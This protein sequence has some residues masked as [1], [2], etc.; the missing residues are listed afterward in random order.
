MLRGLFPPSTGKRYPPQR[1]FPKLSRED[2]HLPDRLTDYSC[3]SNATI[4]ESNFHGYLHILSPVPCLVVMRPV[5]DER[6]CY[7]SASAFFAL[8]LGFF[9]DFSNSAIGIFFLPVVVC[10][11]CLTFSDILIRR[12]TFWFFVLR[13][14]FL[15]IFL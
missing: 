12:L 15:S 8:A 6:T 10:F 5:R 7:Y 1:A 2:L 11:Q 3:V 9:T 4:Y 14:F 13:N